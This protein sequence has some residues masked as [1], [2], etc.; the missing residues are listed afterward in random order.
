MTR[1]RRTCCLSGVAAVVVAAAC[2][3]AATATPATAEARPFLRE[4]AR[5]DEP[6]HAVQPRG[7]KDLYVAERAGRIMLVRKGAKRRRPVLDIRSRVESGYAERGLLSIAPAP[8]FERSRLL[9]AYYTA[10][11]GDAQM[12]VELKL[13]SRGTSVA[14]N[15]GRLAS[16]TVMRMPDRGKSHNGG[17]LQ[18]GPDGYLYVGTGDGG[19]ATGLDRNPQDLTSPLGKILRIDPARS[20]SS[21]Y[22]VPA[23]NPFA[24]GPGGKA[25]EIYAYGLRNPWRFSIDRRSGLLAIGDVGELDVEEVNVLPLAAA[26]GANFGW[27]AFEGS[28]PFPGGDALRPG[29]THVP[30]TYEYPHGPGG[31]FAVTG[32]VF[33][34]DRSLP[35]LYGRYLFADSS[36]GWSRSFEVRDGQAVNLRTH[37]GL[38]RQQPVSFAQG[39]GGRLWL[40]SLTGGVYRVAE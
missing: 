2:A 14:S 30:P 15:K 12:I 9:Y 38:Q 28:N 19:G 21:P 10:E 4:V 34:R 3:I 24:D 31:G 7:T 33:V 5:F 25:D 11:G 35:S 20:G 40:V 23:D 26:R 37:R 1:L 18:F 29:S 36:L 39:R 27:S 32:G 17:L 22:S 8:D 13:D 16:R 6:V